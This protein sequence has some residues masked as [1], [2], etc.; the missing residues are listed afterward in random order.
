MK[1]LDFAAH[2]LFGIKENSYNSSKTVHYV[3]IFM[4]QTN[5]ESESNGQIIKMTMSEAENR[6]RF[7]DFLRLLSDSA[8]F[9]CYFNE[10]LS[11]VPFSAFRWETPGVTTASMNH[12]FE[13][14]LL[15]SPELSRTPDV[16]AF[17][18]YFASHGVDDVA[19]FPNLGNDAILI[20]PCPV[21]M[22][23]AYGHIAAF[24]RNAPEK[25]RDSLW[26]SV[27]QAMTNRLSTQPVWLNTAGAGVAWLHVRLDSRPKYYGYITYKMPPKYKVFE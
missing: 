18:D 2:V 12:Y 3:E 26:K 19:V 9:R 25:Q 13:C 21:A 24:L 10:Q 15:D 1:A 11:L 17:S 14:I 4:W 23:S 7:S 27:G 6:L 20:V 5:T 8:D 16:L 22:D